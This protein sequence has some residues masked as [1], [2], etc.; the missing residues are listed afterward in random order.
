MIDGIT[1][2]D[3]P[4]AWAYDV[5]LCSKSDKIY[6]ILSG[7]I[8]L[9]ED[10]LTPGEFPLFAKSTG[11]EPLPDKDGL[12][13]HF[14]T[15]TQK[16]E[17]VENHIGESGYIDGEYVEV[18]DFGPYPDGF[19]KELPLKYKKEIYENTLKINIQTML[20]STDFLMMPDYPLADNDKNTLKE[21]RNYLRNLDKQ[22]GYPWF[23]DDSFELPAWPLEGVKKCPYTLS[24]IHCTKEDENVSSDK[25]TS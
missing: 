18:V 8:E 4:H 12:V 5:R 16:W 1:V 25:T 3:N 15:S 6:N 2:L 13:Q 20:N 14:N 9:F 21:F 10:P 22:E 24:C 23:G 17:Y 7:P 11:V 19:T